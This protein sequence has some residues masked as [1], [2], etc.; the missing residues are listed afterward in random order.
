M[1]RRREDIEPDAGKCEMKNSE[2]R[3]LLWEN[4][5]R[6]GINVHN[7]YRMAKE[8]KGRG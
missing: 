4:K 8:G 7:M 1:N 3:G 5:S 2:R 6:E